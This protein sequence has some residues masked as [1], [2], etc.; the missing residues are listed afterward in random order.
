MDIYFSW[1]D[2]F[3]KKAQN[4]FN[5]FF[6]LIDFAVHVCNQLQHLGIELDTE[7]KLVIAGGSSDSDEFAS[8]L[9]SLAESDNRI[10][11]TG[12]VQ[13]RTLEELYSNAY[14][15]V[16]PSDLEGMPLSLLEAMSY[17]NCCLTS[18]IPECK[19]VVSE[20]GVTFERGNAISLCE[21]LQLLCDNPEKVKEY[22]ERSAEYICKKYDWDDVVEKTLELYY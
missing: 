20:Y 7:K 17:G 3:R 18:D 19:D 8:A 14:V 22:K 5:F 21:K 1:E 13:G 2:Q 11:F 6:F 12:F 15:Y 16:L 9:K 10:V 4:S